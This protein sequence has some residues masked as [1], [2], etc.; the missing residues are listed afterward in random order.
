M[1]T[2]A[3]L[4]TLVWA[5]TALA[6]PASLVPGD[7][8]ACFN[9][10][11]GAGTLSTVAV[12]GMPFARVLHVKTGSVPATA[13]AWDIRPRC[14]STLAAR[15]NDVVAATFWMRVIAA[16]DGRGFTSFV[17][18]RNDSPYTKSVT[19]T[20][21]AGADWQKFEVPFTMAESYAAN[22]YNFSFWVTFPKIGRAHV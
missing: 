1:F 20:V 16:P 5:S 14:F 7:P 15:Q 12:S 2:R 13:N 21:A 6:D 10:I 17:L 11:D 18:E 9:R 22:A 8:L 3:I 4:A 19:Y